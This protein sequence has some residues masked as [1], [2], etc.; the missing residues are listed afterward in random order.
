LGTSSVTTLPSEKL[1]KSLYFLAYL[2]I[3][4]LKSRRMSFM[5][6]AAR[7]GEVKNALK[8]VVGKPEGKRPLGRPNS[9]WRLILEWIVGKWGE[10]E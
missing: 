1:K 3:R 4:V 6:H 5:G 2:H 10:K 9:R 8:I 7:T